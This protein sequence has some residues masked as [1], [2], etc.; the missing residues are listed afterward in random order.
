MPTRNSLKKGT[1]SPKTGWIT[2]KSPKQVKSISQNAQVNSENETKVNV[3]NSQDENSETVQKFPEGSTLMTFANGS[4][5]VPNFVITNV[6]SLASGSKIQKVI[7]LKKAQNIVLH[8][9][10][11]GTRGQ[12]IGR[13]S[14]VSNTSSITKVSTSFIKEEKIDASPSQDAP[15]WLNAPMK[16]YVAKRKILPVE[17]SLLPKVENVDEDHAYVNK[18]QS[19]IITLKRINPPNNQAK[20]AKISDRIC[21]LCLKYKDNLTPLCLGDRAKPQLIDFLKACC[22]L[23]VRVNLFKEILFSSNLI[24]KL[25]KTLIGAL[26]AAYKL[27]YLLERGGGVSVSNVT[28]SDNI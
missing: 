9:L 14:K 10:T 2:V 7:P 5:K 20:P 15:Q 3:S 21:R 26:G 22:T 1:E 25:P 6:Q 17:A 13:F 11:P 19:P 12:N 23:E 8:N 16:R 28:N 27:R 4:M 24:E 18:Y